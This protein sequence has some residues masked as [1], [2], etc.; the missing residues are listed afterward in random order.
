MSVCA[1]IACRVQSERLYGKPLQRIEDKTILEHLVFQLSYSKKIDQVVLAVAKGT[2]NE[3]FIEVAKKL[4]IEYVFGDMDNVTERLV[5]AARKVG[6]DRIVRHTSDNPMVYKQNLDEMI[7]R[8]AEGG[9]DYVSTTLL[10]D[11]TMAEVVTVEALERSVRDGDQ[12]HRHHAVTQYIFDR[13][14]EFKVLRLDAPEH[15]RRPEIRL[16]ID[17]PE[18]LLLF[19]KMFKDI[20]RPGKH[21]TV[22]EAVEYLDAH[23]EVKALNAGHDLYYTRNWI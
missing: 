6:A 19:R 17:L 21:V 16:T 10:P 20:Y 1:A 14:D 8:Q 23:P 11:G 9:Y 4:G 5:L 15:L 13:Q 2:G 7:D 18:D 22:Q 12:K 3:A